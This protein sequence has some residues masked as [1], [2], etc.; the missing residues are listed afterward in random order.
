M[1]ALVQYLGF[2]ADGTIGIQQVAGAVGLIE[3]ADGKVVTVVV[4]SDGSATFL[5]AWRVLSVKED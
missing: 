1:N 4:E 3:D 2:G 5:P